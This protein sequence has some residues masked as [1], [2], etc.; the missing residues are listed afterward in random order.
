MPA[1]PLAPFAVILTLG[2]VTYELWNGN[3]SQVIIAVGALAVGYAYY[4]DYLRRHRETRW[5]MPAAPHDE[6]AADEAG[7]ILM[8][9]ALEIHP[10]GGYETEH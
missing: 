2:Y 4:Y 6:H 10:V 9:P 1:W 5:T 8:G 3:P 7:G